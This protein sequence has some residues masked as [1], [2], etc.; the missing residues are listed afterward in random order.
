MSLE[1][2]RLWEIYHRKFRRGLELANEKV[3]F[4]ASE[5]T[6]DVGLAMS[7]ELQESPP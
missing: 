6:G 5:R 3:Y 1:I 7:A 4:T 2:P